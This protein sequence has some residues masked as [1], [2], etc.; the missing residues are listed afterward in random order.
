MVSP[1]TAS[2]KRCG[3]D[4]KSLQRVETGSMMV[5]LTAIPRGS[6]WDGQDISGVWI[7]RT[8]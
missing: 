2:Q 7:T 6:L 4:P 5:S 8:E 3:A 1:P